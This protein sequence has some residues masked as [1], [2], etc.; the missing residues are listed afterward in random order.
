MRLSIPEFALYE[1]LL[2]RWQGAINLVSDTTLDTIQTRHFED[3]AQLLPYLSTL[4]GPIGDLGSGA[5]FPGMVLAILG[6]PNIELVESDA[7]KCSFLETVARETNTSVSI[8]NCRIETLPDQYYAAITAR[9]CAPLVELLAL[10][11]PKLQANA[12][13]FF[14]KGRNYTQEVEDAEKQF[15]FELIAHPSVTDPTARLLII[16]NIVKKH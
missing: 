4:S 11:I 3:S 15:S 16:H 10:A 6:L 9:A 2:R 8:R 12:P 14:L 7:R 13:C 5:G 1:R